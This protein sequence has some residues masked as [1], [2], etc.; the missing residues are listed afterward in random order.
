MK[1]PLFSRCLKTGVTQAGA[2]AE[3]GLELTL[4][5]QPPNRWNYSRAPPRTP[6]CTRPHDAYMCSQVWARVPSRP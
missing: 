3:A 4:Q 2:V 5:P 1:N 6:S